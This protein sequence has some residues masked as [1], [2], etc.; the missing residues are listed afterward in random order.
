MKGG[1]RLRSSTATE[2]PGECRQ[3]TTASC[4]AHADGQHLRHRKQTIATAGMNRVKILE[5]QGVHG[6]ELQRIDGTK[7]AQ[8]HRMD[9]PCLARR[10]QREAGH[11]KTNKNGVDHQHTAVADAGNQG[12]DQPLDRDAGQRNRQHHHAGAKRGIPHAKLQ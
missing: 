8:L 3:D 12:R 1:Q 2:Q 4:H 9:P 5:C 11:D 10:C 6:S 7:A